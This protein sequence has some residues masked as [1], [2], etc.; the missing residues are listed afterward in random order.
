MDNFDWPA[1]G[2]D[3]GLT[4][5]QVKF[6]Q[7]KHSGKSNAEAAR[8]AG[9]GG[10]DG[11]R[12]RQE[13]YRLAS[14]AGVVELLERANAAMSLDFDSVLA[15]AERRAPELGR[16]A[17]VE[18]RWVQTGRLPDMDVAVARDIAIEMPANWWGWREFGGDPDAFDAVVSPSELCAMLR[19]RIEFYNEI[20]REIDGTARRMNG[21]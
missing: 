19:R 5:A 11:K 6:A 4:D 14:H 16:A 3:L 21:P 2:K 1:A 15:A 13:G 7:A 8:E 17:A 10:E 12:A 20:I 18:E 9:L